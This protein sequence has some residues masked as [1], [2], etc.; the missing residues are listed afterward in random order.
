MAGDDRISHLPDDLLQH[1][2]YFAPAKEAASTSALARRWRTQWLSSG[3]VNLDTSSYPG[4]LYRKRPAFVRDADAALAARGRR[5]PLRK[6]T[7]RVEGN[8][9]DNIRLFLRHGDDIKGIVDTVLTHVAARSVEEL[10]IYARLEGRPDGVYYDITVPSLLSENLRVLRISGCRYLKIPPVS[11][12]VAFPR[13]E[14]LRIHFCYDV[15]LQGL[16]RVIDSTPHLAVLDLHSVCIYS[17]YDVPAAAVDYGSPPPATLRCPSVTALVLSD[18]TWM[19]RLHGKDTTGVNLDAPMLRWF[20]YKPN[21]NCPVALKSQATSLTRLDID[22]CHDPCAATHDQI[23]ASLWQCVETFS[24]TRVLKLK[25]SDIEHVSGSE[26]KKVQ[27][28]GSNMVLFHN[29]ERLELEVHYMPGQ[30]KAA[31]EAIAY[32]LRCCPVISKLRLSLST[33]LEKHHRYADAYRV[34]DQLDFGKSVDQFFSRHGLK[35]PMITYEVCDHIHGLSGESFACLQSSL[36]S[37]SLR[38][39]REKSD[40]FG[41]RLVKFFAEN[42][43]VLEKMYIDDGNQKLH[44]HINHTVGRWVASSSSGF[45]VLPLGSHWQ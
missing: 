1:I 17:E 7:F 12:P 22:F 27:L 44:E 11:V 16:Q 25:W 38:F 3:A 14:E 34:K 6:L 43:M 30:S 31:G 20:R 33:T 41:V 24:N 2:L 26:T 21:L 36:R 13:L 37:V 8:H 40:I 10:C 29:L 4:L 39:R 42:A 9:R 35:N 15:Q 19:D 23:W 28:P 18:C 32:I 45:A 5:W